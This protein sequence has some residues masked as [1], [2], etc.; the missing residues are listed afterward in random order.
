MENYNFKVEN[1]KVIHITV[2]IGVA[3]F[4]DTINNADKIS[5]KADEGLYKAKQNGRNKVCVG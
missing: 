1:N 5:E 2:S 3:V 4:P